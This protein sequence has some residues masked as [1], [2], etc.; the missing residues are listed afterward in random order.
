MYRYESQRD[1]VKNGQ[2]YS[3]EYIDITCKKKELEKYTITNE[4]THNNRPKRLERH[5]KY[6]PKAIDTF[7]YNLTQLIFGSTVAFIDFDTK[8]VSIIDA[9]RFALFHPRIFKKLFEKL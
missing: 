5:S 4:Q 6:I 7:E 9:K 3:R 8:T 1:F 2:Y